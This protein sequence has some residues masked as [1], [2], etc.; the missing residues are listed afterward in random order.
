MQTFRKP[1]QWL[2]FWLEKYTDVLAGLKYSGEQRKQFWATLKIFLEKFP[3]NPRNLDLTAIGAYITENTDERLQPIILFYQHVAPSKPH[4][5]MLRKMVASMDTTS[6]DMHADPV[7]R[8]RALLSDK[9]FSPRTVKN[10]STVAASFLRWC[11]D[12]PEKGKADKIERYC[13]YLAVDKKLSERT[14]AL[15]KA[16]LK[17]F[18]QYVISDDAASPT[19]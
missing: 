6:S 4:L 13:R 12:T 17:L 10:Y 3:G 19:V 9:N 2:N 5:E 11:E 7:E 1:H 16:A 14:I 8:F 18:Y 15:H